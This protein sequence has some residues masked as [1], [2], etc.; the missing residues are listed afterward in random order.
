MSNHDISV[1]KTN[2]RPLSGPPS[3]NPNEPKQ[4]RMMVAALTLLLISL[5]FVLYRDRDFW[6]PDSQESDV[7]SQPQPAVATATASPSQAASAKHAAPV[8]RKIRGRRSEAQSAPPA[9]AAPSDASLAAASTPP[10]SITRTILPPL[11]V[12]VV[13]GDNHRTVRPGTNSVRVDLQP[14]VSAPENS[15]GS[16]STTALDTAAGVT[17]NAAEHVQ[18]SADTAEVVSRPVKPGYPLLARQMKVQGSVILQ[19][20]IGRDGLIQDLHVLSGPP[21]L[22]NAAQEAV[23][24]WHFK[25]H[26]EG[27][28]AVET[29]A[30]ITVNFTISTN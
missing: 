14:P 1:T 24:Q 21:I 18:I 8:R 30:K 7:Q 20:M 11:E 2:R 16:A 15:A 29:Q 27:A 12:E 26:Y 9:I 4:R 10:V 23:K 22:A 28:G 13:A 19:A 17:T 5:G 3:P 6:F 25:P